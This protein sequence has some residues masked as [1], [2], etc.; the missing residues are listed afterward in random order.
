MAWGM[1]SR[2]AKRCRPSCGSQVHEGY[3]YLVANILSNRDDH[4]ME[5]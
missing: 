2:S 1:L 4:L 3:A 5:S